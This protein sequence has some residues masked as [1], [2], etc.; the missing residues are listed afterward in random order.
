MVRQM[1]KQSSCYIIRYDGEIVAST[2]TLDNAY[3]LIFELAVRVKRMGLSFDLDAWDIEE[4]IT[5]CFHVN[6]DKIAYYLED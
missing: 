2:R 5:T 1:A 6:P 3:Q 4:S